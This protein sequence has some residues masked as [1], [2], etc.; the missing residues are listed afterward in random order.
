MHISWL[1]IYYMWIEI[2]W[3]N[4]VGLYEMVK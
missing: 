4:R 3:K 1:V 2:E